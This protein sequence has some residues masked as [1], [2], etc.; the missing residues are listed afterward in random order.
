[1]EHDVAVRAYGQH[2]FL[3]TPRAC[4]L[5]YFNPSYLRSLHV[6]SFTSKAPFGITIHADGVMSYLRIT[7]VYSVDDTESLVHLTLQIQHIS[8]HSGPGSSTG[9][10]QNGH[11]FTRSSSQLIL[12]PPPSPLLT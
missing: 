4:R 12:F 6:A 11:F 9:L 3:S 1:M 2:G 8:D 5:S 10:W 7:P